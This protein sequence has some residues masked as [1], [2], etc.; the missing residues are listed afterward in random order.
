MGLTL[1]ELEQRHILRVLEHH[2]DNRSA[3]ARALGISRATL[4]EK[5]H[6]YGLS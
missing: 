1:E 3:A 2:N 4:Y 5:L 6:K